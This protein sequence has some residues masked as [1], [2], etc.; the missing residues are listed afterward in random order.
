MGTPALT[1]KQVKTHFATPPPGTAPFVSLLSPQW[2]K[3]HI[4]VRL[5]HSITRQ[6]A[7]P[8]LMAEFCQAPCI[9]PIWHFLSCGSPRCPGLCLN[10]AM[11]HRARQIARDEAALL[12]LHRVGLAEL[13]LRSPAHPEQC[14]PQRENVAVMIAWCATLCD[15]PPRPYSIDWF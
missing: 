5:I 10:L 15:T 2:C 4:H 13:L 1:R 6:S 7:E 9:R 14:A 12:R 11:K 3:R 8:P